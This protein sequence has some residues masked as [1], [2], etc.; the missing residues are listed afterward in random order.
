MLCFICSEHRGLPNS[1]FF[2][3]LT[4]MFYDGFLIV[5]SVNLISECVSVGI[6]RT[7]FG[8]I[9]IAAVNKAVEH[10][11]HDNRYIRFHSICASSSV[12]TNAICFNSFSKYAPELIYSFRRGSFSDNLITEA[13]NLYCSLIHFK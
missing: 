4:C 2:Q 1:L 3:F 13:Y 11:N 9:F 10:L 12:Q 6:E 7:D 8:K 5:R